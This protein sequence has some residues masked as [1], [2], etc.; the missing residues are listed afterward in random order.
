MRAVWKLE[1]LVTGLELY[2]GYKI[3][4]ENTPLIFDEVQEVPKAL[5]SLKY[6]N[7]D[8]PQYQIICAQA[9]AGGG[10]SSRNLFSCGQGGV[11]RPISSVLFEFIMAMGKAPYVDLL[12][13][14]DFDMAITF[15]QDYIDLLK[16]Y[17]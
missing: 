4:P 11:S 13:R 16:H 9:P 1:R 2:A 6:F 7:E 15:K 3:D 12:K 14:S 10:A 17:Y 8:A 5:T